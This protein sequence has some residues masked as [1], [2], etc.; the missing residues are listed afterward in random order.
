MFTV[1]NGDEKAATA[2]MLSAILVAYYS[3]LASSWPTKAERKLVGNAVNSL[4]FIILSSAGAS[5]IRM[6][7]FLSL[8]F[9]SAKLVSDFWNINKLQRDFY[10]NKK[11]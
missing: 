11:F 5:K 8:I 1:L 7:D 6:K 9:S 3:T 10:C 4:D 2:I